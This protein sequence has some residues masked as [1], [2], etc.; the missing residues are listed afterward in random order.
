MRMQQLG[1]IASIWRYPVKSL[2]PEALPGVFVDSGGVPG[3]R[4]R[5]LIV[6]A[7]HARLGKTYRGKE[8]NLLHLSA[9]TQHATE[10]AKERGAIVTLEHEEAHY[11]DAAPISILFDTWLAQ[12]SELVGYPLEPLRYRPNFFVHAQ[13]SFDFAERELLGFHLKVGDAEF[14]VS[15]TIDRCVT[16]TYDVA[17]GEPDPR[18]LSELAQRRDNVMGVYCEVSSPGSCSVGD[19]IERLQ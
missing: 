10:L 2:A 17:T 14:R 15:D 8:N 12:G 19:A 4:A 6:R 1:R 16:I 13:N 5:A 9:S 11:F 7:G 3:D 18:I